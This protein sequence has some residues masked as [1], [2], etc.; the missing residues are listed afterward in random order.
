MTATPTAETSGS[1]TPAARSPRGRP[2][3]PD[4]ARR[5]H[6]AALGLFAE[7]GWA[8]FTLDGVAARARIGK[9][10]IYL[11]WSDRAELLVEALRRLQDEDEA[12][13]SP[14]TD[15]EGPSALGTTEPSAAEPSTPGPSTAG[16]A[17]TTGADAAPAPRTLRDYLVQH[18]RR[19]AEQYLGEHGMA[20]IRLYAEAQTH[21]ELLSEVRRQAL[22][23]Y[24]LAERER[25]AEAVR[26]GELAPDAS[27]MR[28][29][30]AV[31][32][33]VLM[34]VIVTPPHLR[35]R[36]RAT[37][38]EYVELMVD[39]QLRAAGYAFPS[40]GPRTPAT[41]PTPATATTDDGTGTR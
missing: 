37:I 31:E 15:D 1:P 19:R 9:S 17:T 30:D 32:G 24:V 3:D 35:D 5:A 11:R 28:I 16:A 41:P 2:R 20:M 40:T 18:A 25:V 39:D 10:A 21:P 13:P 4:L 34:H 12:R 7:K 22:T 14:P 6:R 23:S 29:L 27:P 33:A 8:G 36:V 26:Q 38:D